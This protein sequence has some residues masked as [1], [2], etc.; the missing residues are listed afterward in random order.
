M[1]EIDRRRIIANINSDYQNW[2][3]L[4]KIHQ[5]NSDL[6]SDISFDDFIFANFYREL[7]HFENI[8][9]K[10]K[11]NHRVILYESGYTDDLEYKKV[12][13]DNPECKFLRYYCLE[14][15]EKI[16]FYNFKHR[17]VSD[18]CPKSVILIDNNIHK[19]DYIST[20]MRMYY[21]LLYHYDTST[22]TKMLID[23]FNKKDTKKYIKRLK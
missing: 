16:D 19:I 12:T 5:N 15:G 21:I 23:E 9:N 2:K 7:N 22:A 4:T 3:V 20:F 1:E 17:E 11:C 13:S 6:K 8:N 10:R 14:C 18:I